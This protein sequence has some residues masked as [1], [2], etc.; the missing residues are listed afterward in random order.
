MEHVFN[1]KNSN[2][3]NDK[4]V[5]K[6]LSGNCENGHGNF[7]TPHGKGTIEYS[8]EFKNGVAHGHGRHVANK[9]TEYVGNFDKGVFHGEGTFTNLNIGSIYT[10]EF[11]R[12][13]R[14]GR[15]K[16]NVV[17]DKMVY[18][19]GWKD[20]MKNGHGKCENR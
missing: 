11:E 7:T 16:L 3:M 17:K 8:G 20:D 9:E 13:K 4:R 5:S 2:I 18:E 1:E 14:S 15:G 10:G 12:G 6:C 19:G